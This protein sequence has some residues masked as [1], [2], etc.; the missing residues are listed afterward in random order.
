MVLLRHSCLLQQESYGMLNILGYGSTEKAEAQ[1]TVLSQ[2]EVKHAE[3]L[4]LIEQ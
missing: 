4:S 1:A 2:E 3:N